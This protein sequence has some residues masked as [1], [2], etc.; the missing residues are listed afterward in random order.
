MPTMSASGLQAG[1]VIAIASD[2]I[3]RVLCSEQH[4]PRFDSAF[5]PLPVN[6]S[7]VNRC[8][9]TEVSRQDWRTQHQLRLPSSRR[10]SVTSEYSI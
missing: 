4:V 2:A 5:K 3:S 8:P 7:P 1:Q 10:T 6:P 9:V